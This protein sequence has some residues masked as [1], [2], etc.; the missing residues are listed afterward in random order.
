[1]ATD[2]H[3]CIF[4]TIV[5]TFISLIALVADTIAT[6][7]TRVVTSA[8]VQPVK[9]GGILSLHCQISNLAANHYVTIS[10]QLDD[11]LDPEIL[12]W[13]DDI[14]GSIGDS[15]FLAVR[16]LND[17]SIIY[18]LSIIGVTIRDQGRYSCKVMPST[19][20]SV[21]AIDHT[22]IKVMYFPR[23]PNP[24]CTPKQS[25][26]VYAG[27]P[28][29]LN[30]TSQSANP[31]VTMDWSRTGSG[32]VPKSMTVQ[33]DGL[34]YTE[35]RLRASLSDNEAVFLCQITSVAFPG[36]VKTCHVGPIVV[37]PNPNDLPDDDGDDKEGTPGG[38]NTD[39]NRQ[40]IFYPPFPVAD[41]FPTTAV[42]LFTDKTTGDHQNPIAD[43]RDVCSSFSSPKFFWIVATVVACALAFL[44]FLM[45]GTLLWKYRQANAQQHTYYATNAKAFAP[46]PHHQHPTRE[47]IYT[48][49]ESKRGTVVT[50]SENLGSCVYMSLERRENHGLGQTNL[51]MVKS[52]KD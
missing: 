11:E 36:K 9:E 12:S 28:L 5:V 1:M 21:V 32:S 41:P 16:Q 29:T 20:D 22:D 48:E 2:K 49:L 18:F 45:G 15:F 7:E 8:P 27:T 37:L 34:S 17:G 14:L 10:R 51:P 39:E 3:C 24:L 31:A 40:P 43:C 6:S 33:R 30:C 44:F 26:T 42:D 47:Y 23:D 50:P 35:L 52:S 19:Q 38:D 4:T 25:L 46:H 13:G